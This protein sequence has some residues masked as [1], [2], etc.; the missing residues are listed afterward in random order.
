MAGIAALASHRL[1]T[2]RKSNRIDN[3]LAAQHVLQYKERPWSDV[4]IV[5][6]GSYYKEMRAVGV[7]VL[8]NRL[9]EFVKLAAA[10]ET[11]LVTDRERVVAELVPP[12]SGRHTVLADAVLADAVRQGWITAPLV[13]PSTPP[14]NTPVARLADLVRELRDDREGR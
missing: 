6:P 7:K 2:Q 3:G 5:A 14:P 11:I 1:N 9:S 4:D 12:R 10:G 8:K 13:A